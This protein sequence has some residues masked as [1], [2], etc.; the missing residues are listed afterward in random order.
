MLPQRTGAGY[1]RLDKTPCYTRHQTPDEAKGSHQTRHRPY[2]NEHRM[3]RNT[4][5]GQ[6]GDA[7]N[8]ILATQQ[9]TTPLSGSNSSETFCSPL[10][11]ATF[12]K[13]SINCC[14]DGYKSI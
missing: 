5:K 2:K 11:A 8:A 12:S 6:Q 9:D 10:F 13:Q 1:S 3:E 7:I 4:L 14:L